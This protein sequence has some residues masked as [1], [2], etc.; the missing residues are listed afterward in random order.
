[1]IG[2]FLFFFS[3]LMLLFNEFAGAPFITDILCLYTYYPAQ[4][5]LAYSILH[6]KKGIDKNE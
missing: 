1:M 2:S 5:L 4:I 6:H 3:D